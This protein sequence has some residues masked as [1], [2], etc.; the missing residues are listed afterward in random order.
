MPKSGWEF[1]EQPHPKFTEELERLGRKK[2]RNVQVDVAEALAEILDRPDQ[3]CHAT[4][5]PGF[6]GQLWKY[7]CRSRD[8]NRG[9]SGGFRLLI[10]R[11]EDT[12]I[13]VPI[14]IY[15]HDEFPGQPPNIDMKARLRSVAP[16]RSGQNPK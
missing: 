7:R 3:A 14:W 6:D 4:P 12:K 16:N 2:Y 1:S 5:I 10:C 9:L 8:M 13:L 11:N 15:T